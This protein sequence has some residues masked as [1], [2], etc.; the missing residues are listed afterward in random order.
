MYAYVRLCYKE[1][2]HELQK[3][4]PVVNKM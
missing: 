2:S 1:T 4:N 3:I